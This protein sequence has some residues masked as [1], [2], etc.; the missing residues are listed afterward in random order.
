V[1][2]AQQANQPVPSQPQQ[3]ASSINQPAQSA[4]D[5]SVKDI[6]ASSLKA[7][8]PSGESTPKASM[9]REISRR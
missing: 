6:E 1:E 5:Q 9:Y 4:S 8:Q 2:I 7:V 3:T